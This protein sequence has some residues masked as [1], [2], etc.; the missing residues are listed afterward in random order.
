MKKLMI[1]AVT[2]AVAGG[3]FALPQVYDYKASVKHLYL[4]EITV[5]VKDVGKVKV[6]QKY[7]KTTGLRGYLVMD[8]DGVTSPSINVAGVGGGAVQWGDANASLGF[9]YGRNRGFLI[10]QNDKAWAGVRFPKILP[11][12]LDAKWIDADGI[13]KQ[14]A[15][16]SGLAEGTLYV[17]GEAIAPVRPAL[18]D[19]AGVITQRKKYYIGQPDV[20]VTKSAPPLP[21]AN[22][23]DSVT[24]VS[25][26]VPLAGMVAIADYVWTSVYLFAD[27]KE[28]TA[29]FNGPNWFYRSGG[30][31]SKRTDIDVNSPFG[32]F[33]YVWDQNLPGD[34]RTGWVK[35]KDAENNDRDGYFKKTPLNYYHDTWMNGAG[36]GK[37]FTKNNSTDELCCGIID[38]QNYNDPRTLDT[39]AGNLKG[40]LFLCTENG[41]LAGD[42]AYNWFLFEEWEDQFNTARAGGD[43]FRFAYDAWQNDLWQDGFID[44]AT[45]DVI[46]GTWSIK[47]N[48]TFFTGKGK[49]KPMAIADTDWYKANFPATGDGR[50]VIIDE[51]LWKTI[52]G[53]AYALNTKV[54]IYD[55]T[56][57]Y[58]K[59]IQNRA[60]L[61]MITP[62]F[63][64]YY[65]LAV[66]L[67]IN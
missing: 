22:V 16:L 36:V 59:D 24:G 62:K 33:E 46:Y 60:N 37:W 40:G 63:A 53:A 67:P 2:A 23:A 44:Q 28:K 38:V 17:G 35:A 64:I 58:T 48:R 47:F 10:V 5:S 56:E 66:K 25:E 7:Q 13:K 61:P 50:M 65:R 29:F 6:Y 52:Y 30:N 51:T 3:A 15:Q 32:Q 20:E 1:A 34:L 18:D 39:L 14:K 49:A 42:P 9:D 43:G 41:I 4:Q 55:G 12:I 57:I 19:L 54:N 8:Q 45:T 31:P 21:V 26:A 27:S 11:A